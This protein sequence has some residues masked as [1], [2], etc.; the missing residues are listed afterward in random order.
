MSIRSIII[1]RLTGDLDVAKDIMRR[2][3]AFTRENYG[4]RLIFDPYIDESTNKVI[5]VNSAVDEETAVSWERDMGDVTRLRDE[6]M[7]VMEMVSMDI[8]DPITDPRL[9]R[10]RNAGTILKSMLD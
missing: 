6:V 2:V 9:E 10:I 7:Q 8:L 5:W 3:S 4:D 1:L